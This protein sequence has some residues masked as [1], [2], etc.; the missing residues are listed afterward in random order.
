[1]VGTRFIFRKKALSEGVITLFWS[2]LAF[3]SWRNPLKLVK[4][5]FST[6][7]TGQNSPIDR[8][9][10][11]QGSGFQEV[12]ENRI[13]SYEANCTQICTKWGL[14][15][16]VLNRPESPYSKGISLFLSPPHLFTVRGPFFFSLPQHQEVEEFV[17]CR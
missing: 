8:R 1:M 16:C 10:L 5:S 11:I 2:A 9:K 14:I 15:I 6:E 4:S 3:F 17:V 7:F 13:L 12:F